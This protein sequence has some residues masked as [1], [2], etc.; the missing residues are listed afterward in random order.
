[1][2]SGCRKTP[3]T[4]TVGSDPAGVAVD[5]A[6]DTIYVANS[7]GTTVS[8]INGA[9]CNGKVTSGCGRK[10]RRVH[11]GKSPW[12]VAVN[13]AT[14][15]IYA[16]NP[17][18][19]G[20]VSV[21]NGATC[22]GTVTSGCGKPPPTVTVG[23]GNVVAGLAVNQAT[24][25]IYAV[26]TIDNTVSVIN[27]ATCN[28]EGHLRAAARARRTWTS[29]GRVFG[30]AAVDPATDLVYVIEQPATTPFRSSTEPPATGR[31]PQAAIRPRRPF[32]AGADPSRTGPRPG[33]PHRLR[34]RQRRRPA[35]LL[36]LSGPGA[37]RPA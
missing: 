26:N 30:F 34:R 24:D 6:T 4:V 19:P 7:G 14:D 31:S 15:T 28:A 35:V 12:A 18:T 25:T 20:T 3:P 1:M 9:A 27:G 33:Q 29:A 8:V 17:G 13:Q 2:T 37:P 16:L 22:N 21:I 32:T 36:P 11:L 23:N 10:P 5:Q